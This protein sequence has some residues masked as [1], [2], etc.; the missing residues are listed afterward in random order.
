MLEKEWLIVLGF[1]CVETANR[2]STNRVRAAH[3]LHVGFE[4]PSNSQVGCVAQPR[5]RSVGYA[6]YGLLHVGFEVTVGV[7]RNHAR[8]RLSIQTTVC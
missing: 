2:Q 1:N 8:D 6:G 7:W 5:T 3:T 4:V